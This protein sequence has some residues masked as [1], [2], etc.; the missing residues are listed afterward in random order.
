LSTGAVEAAPGEERAADFW[1]RHLGL[2]RAAWERGRVRVVE[3]AALA[4]YR[5]AWLFVRGGCGVVS[6][7]P[8]WARSVGDVARALE[9]AAL[10]AEPT[11]R[12]LFAD[13]VERTVGPAW[14]G[15][16]DR[17]A[18]RPAPHPGVRP[19]GAADRDAVAAFARAADPQEWVS[20][21]VDP[22]SGPLWGVYE[23][24]ALRGLASLRRLEPDVVDPGV[25]TLPPA[26]GRGLGAALV[27]AAVAQPLASGALVLFQ[28]LAANAP[29][30]A[31]AGRLGFCADAAHLAVRLSRGEP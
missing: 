18:F 26:R 5:G 25:I 16:L 12:L 13:A 2:P 1:A 3:H 27:S 30:R 14:W 10:L 31:L 8:A 6:V 21:N 4:G 11:A 28:T 22:S 17:R 19:L 29:A 15:R 24:G 20:A 23:G 9:P 7:P